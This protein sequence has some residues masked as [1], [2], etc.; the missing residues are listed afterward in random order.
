MLYHQ[1]YRKFI[2]DMST[3]LQPLNELLAKKTKWEWN[4]KC[5]KSF[6]KICELLSSSEVLAHYDPNLDGISR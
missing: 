5:K 2:P 6:K 1:Y 4:E 3:V